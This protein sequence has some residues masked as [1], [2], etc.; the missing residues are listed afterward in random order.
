MANIQLKTFKDI[1]RLFCAI[2]L[3]LI[4]LYLIQEKKTSVHLFTQIF[5]TIWNNQN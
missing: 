3:K 2:D 5:N 1:V 4:S